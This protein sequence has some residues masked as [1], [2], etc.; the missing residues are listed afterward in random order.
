MMAQTETCAEKSWWRQWLVVPIINQ[1]KAGTTPECISWAIALGMVL[2]VF[3]VLGST[4]LVCFL[5]AWFFRLNQ[6]VIQVFQW[7]VYP[8][9]LA[10]ILVFIRMGERLFGAPSMPLSIQQLIVKFKDD[11][12]QF[13]SDFGM[14]ALYGVI[15]W[16]LIAPFA[17][18]LIKVSVMPLVKKLA[19][20]LRTRKE[21]M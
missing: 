21:A 10:L 2:G 20:S 13:A 17:V 3:P 6:A 9:H 18:I 11:P 1:L 14:S 15:A 7:L 19:E 4:T 5:A 12:F 8:L 16:L